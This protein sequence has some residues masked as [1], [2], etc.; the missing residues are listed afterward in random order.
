MEKKNVLIVGAGYMAREYTKVLKAMN[1]EMTVVGRGVESA[2][3][4]QSETGVNVITG[5]I[6]SY[7]EANNDFP[8]YAIITVRSK[9]LEECSIKLLNAGV[10]NILIEKPGALSKE[11]IERVGKLSKEKNANCFI[12]YNR[13]FYSSVQTAKE[14]IEADG[15]VTSF[16]FE[17]TEWP[18]TVLAAIKDTNERNE[19]MINN[20]SHV[21][22]M[23]FFLGGYPKEMQ[24]YHSG[25]LDWHKYGAVF[26]GAGVSDKGALFSY[27]AN[28]NAPGRWG[29]EIL[30]S[31]HRYIFRPLEK[32]QI[33][34]M[35]SVKIAEVEID[36][37]IDTDFKPGLYREVVAFLGQ[38][39]YDTDLC[40]LDE[41]CRDF[42]YYY[43][44]RGQEV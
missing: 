23:A 22:D 43:R 11:G 42:E 7:I 1:V 37:T 17:F 36:D 5:G 24:S 12:A 39:P 32:L 26:A 27:Q 29:A 16:T 19:I 15:G 3:S 6:E 8:E 33:Q 10:K 38:N 4:F 40:T 13:R 44:I 41:Q 28:Y 9:D 34:E 31:K 18:K 35:N 2:E 25:N 21:I 20:S 14:M 30:T